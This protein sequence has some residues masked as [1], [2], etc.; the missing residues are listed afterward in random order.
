MTILDLEFDCNL[1][2]H[3]DLNIYIFLWAHKLGFDAMIH[4]YQS[5]LYLEHKCRI[6]LCRMKKVVLGR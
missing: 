3:M 2:E 1:L 5:S 4:F 6:R